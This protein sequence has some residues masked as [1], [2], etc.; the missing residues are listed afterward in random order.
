[1]YCR[2]PEKS[3][4]PMVL[5]SSTRR[6]PAGPPRCWIYGCSSEPLEGWRHV[7]V[8]ER[9]TAVD[10]AHVLKDISDIHFKDAEKIVL[11]QD[12]LNTHAP[13]SRVYLNGLKNAVQSHGF[14][15]APLFKKA[16]KSPVLVLVIRAQ[17]GR[18]HLPLRRSEPCR[19]AER[20]TCVIANGRR[21]GFPSRSPQWG[22]STPR[23]HPHG[24]HNARRNYER[25]LALAQAEVQAGDRFAAENYYQHAEHYFR[26][27][28]SE[29]T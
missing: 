9:R 13:A 2:F 28:S 14:N 6:N 8:T 7:K 22:S 5:S 26:S 27:M 23:P 4:K 11:L 19:M 16:C 18:L 15:T 24:T 17:H 3:T 1:M 25:Y 29:Q 12:N 20:Q 10:Y 21:P